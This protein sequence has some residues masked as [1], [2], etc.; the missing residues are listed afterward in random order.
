MTKLEEVAR[1]IYAANGWWRAVEDDDDGLGRYKDGHGSDRFRAIE[2]EQLPEED[3]REHLDSARRAVKALREP[4][5]AMRRVGVEA[6]WQSPV[7]DANNVREIFTAMIDAILSE[8]DAPK[9]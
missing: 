4:D 5:E 6:R 9:P 8:G 7:R 3:R 1:A 2:W